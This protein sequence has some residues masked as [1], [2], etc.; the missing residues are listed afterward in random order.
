M[1]IKEMCFQ[2]YIM[3]HNAL[4]R[5]G[6]M[7]HIICRVHHFGVGRT[8]GQA[9]YTIAQY[10]GDNIAAVILTFQYPVQPQLV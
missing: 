1:R 10:S 7:P 5:R 6:F 2:N 8:L 9:F 4:P 3:R